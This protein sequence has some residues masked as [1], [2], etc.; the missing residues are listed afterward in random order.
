[1]A[2]LAA[3]NC[4]KDGELYLI[5]S[6]AK[7]C[8]QLLALCVHRDHDTFAKLSSHIKAELLIVWCLTNI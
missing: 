3:A 6:D 1:M 7:A 4:P 8:D 5:K 2:V